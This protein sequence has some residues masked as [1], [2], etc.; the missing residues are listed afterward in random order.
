MTMPAVWRRVVPF[1]LIVAGVSAAHGQPP[2]PLTIEQVVAR[3]LERNLVV[4]AARHRVDHARAEQIGAQLYPNPTLTIGTENLKLGGPTPTGDLYEV[5]ATVSQPI[6][7]SDKR[8]HRRE[9]ADA[10]VA[11]AEAELA[12]TLGQR[13]LEAK[14]AFHETLLAREAVEQAAE[15]RQSFDEVVR[16][17][18]A[19]FKEGAVAESEL[20]RVR[21]ERGRLDTASLETDLALRQAGIKLLDLLGETDFSGAGTVTGSTRLPS[22]TLEDVAVLKADALQRRPSIRAAEQTV[23]LAERRV[24]LER[25]RNTADFAPFVGFRRVGENNTVLFGV[26]I[27]LPIVDRNQAGIARA[28]AEERAARTELALRKNRVLAEVESAFQAWENARRRA[29]T[30]EAT[31]VPQADESQAI[32]RRAYQEGAIE[33]IALLDAQRT[34]AQLRQQYRQSVLEARIALLVLEQAVGREL[35]R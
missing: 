34:L 30:F 3:V 13:L 29:Q 18:E 16:V 22:A 17:T 9:V 4:E 2:G 12:D 8:R 31:L 7:R 28:G 32:A 6:E 15:T 35:A 19:R 25:T 26:A 11:V 24:A 5:G 27:P 20:I 23:T 10:G 1:A 21:L 14:R 33:L